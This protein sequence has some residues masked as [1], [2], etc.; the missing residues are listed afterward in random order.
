MHVPRVGSLQNNADGRAAAGIDEVMLQRRHRQQ[1]RNGHVVLI[2]APVGQD[3][4]IGPILVR[5]VTG[6]EQ[7][8]QRPFQR[9]SP[10]IQNGNIRHPQGLLL[11][12][13]DA[14]KVGVGQDR[15]FQPQHGAVFRLILQKVAIAAHVHRR[16]G[17]DFFPNGVDGRVSDLCEKLPEV[18]EQHLM[19]FRKHGQR[20]IRPHGGGRLCTGAGH[21]K[22]DLLHVLIGIAESLVQPVPCGLLQGRNGMIGQGQI[23][24]RK[25]VAVQPF[26]VGLTGGVFFLQL[27]VLDDALLHRIHQQHL[28]GAH[29]G[30]LHDLFRG[31]VQN[32]HFAGKHQHS[33]FG[34]IVAG[35]PQTV[36]VQHRAHH[37]AVG[38]QNGGGA[39]PGLHHGGVV[40]VQITPGAGNI[41]FVLP[42][43]RDG[44]HHSQGQGHAVH[45]QKFQRIIQHGRV[46]AFAVDNRQHLVHI[47]LHQRGAEGLLPGDHPIHVAADGVDLAVVQ[48]EPV[49]VRPLPAGEGVSGKAGMHHGNGAGEVFALQVRIKGPKLADQKHSLIDHGAA[50]QRAY[51]RIGVALLKGPANHIQPPVKVNALLQIGRPGDKALLDDGHTGP[52]PFA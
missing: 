24:E 27:A 18:R 8:I 32:A 46:A 49:G 45:H 15:L 10:I 11:G 22:D 26:A 30:F 38:E 37:V 47:A 2:H 12:A 43:L 7:V 34:N 1:G 33:V 35:G 19:L 40:A 21:G 48:D 14:Q 28:A 31:N 36:A 23:V 52:R 4:D 5:P 42:R 51:I 9:L 39:V 16:I 6:H 29:P 25:Q 13:A 41:P 20:D 50:G 17:D 3:Q 44:H